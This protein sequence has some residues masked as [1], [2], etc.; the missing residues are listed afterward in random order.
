[1][2][3]SL[4]DKLPGTTVLVGTVPDSW[5][6]FNGHMADSYY[7]V[8]LSDAITAFM[9]LIGVDDRYRRATRNTIYTME[10]RTI[11]KQECHAGEKFIVLLQ[12]VDLDHKR[13]HAFMRVVK[14]D[15]SEDAAWGEQMLIHVHQNS[16]LGPKS[17][18]FPQEIKATLD[19]LLAEH[20]CDSTPDWVGGRMGIHR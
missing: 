20:S 14:A 18:P 10:A 13:F 17:S 8:I 1:M 4:P 2:L 16:E 5:L 9:D 7:G 6:D 3:S 12:L 15:T 19:R 11:F